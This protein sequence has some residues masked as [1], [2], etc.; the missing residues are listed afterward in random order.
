MYGKCW[1]CAGAD[2][3]CYHFHCGSYCSNQQCGTTGSAHVAVATG[4]NATSTFFLPSEGSH[5]AVFDPSTLS[6]PEGREGLA[7]AA[8]GVK[9]EG[10]KEDSAKEAYPQEESPLQKNLAEVFKTLRVNELVKTVKSWAAEESESDPE[11]KEEPEQGDVSL[12][13]EVIA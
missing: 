3:R 2:N 6:K 10:V 7:A 4:L 13:V 8:P 1:S 5:V 9:V 12:L 11:S